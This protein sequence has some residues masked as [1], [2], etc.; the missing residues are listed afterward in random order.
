MSYLLC[1]EKE[2]PPFYHSQEQV[3][4]FY[5]NTT[6]NSVDQRKIRAIAARSGIKGRYSAIPDFSAD[7]Q[8]FT[9][10]PK[11]HALEPLPG[12]GPRMDLF[13]LE[14][15]KLSLAAVQRIRNFQNV[16]ERITHLITVTCTGLSAP[17]LDIE[18]MRHLELNPAT[19]RSSVNFMGCNAAVI[20]MK[21]AND[22]CLAHTGALVLVVC[23]ELCTI[24]FQ[25]EYSEDYLLSNLIF[26]DGAAALLI[27]SR[28]EEIHPSYP[29][30][31]IRSFHSL[32]IHEGIREMA[33]H[34]T[35]KGFIM[36]LT[37]YVSGM[38]NS[39]IG[40]L[41]QQNGFEPDE[42]DQW[43]IHPGGK[44][45][46]EDF[47]AELGLKREQLSESFDVLE[48]YGNM[49]SAT[50]LF[51]LQRVLEKKQQGRIFAAAFGPGLSIESMV[52]SHA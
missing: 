49:S 32:I 10:F 18:L 21:Q 13:K 3:A 38:L 7:P 6:N 45:I 34:I 19:Q 17:G 29:V 16:R 42:T 35:E 51:V 39:R 44:R 8:D 1:I 2:N 24:H 23:T 20:A 11:N 15:L 12:V 33:W 50:I 28:K 31:E 9:F 48:Q 41:F 27:G 22:I 26:G 46:L 14:S 52:L 30:A 4:R 36:N 43:A 25:K 37:S 5:S 40:Q 47:I